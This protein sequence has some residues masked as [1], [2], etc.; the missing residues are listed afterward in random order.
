MNRAAVLVVLTSLAIVGVGAWLWFD[1][2]D[3][4]GLKFGGY[5]EAEQVQVGSRLGGRVVQVLVEEGSEVEAGQD[6]AIFETDEVEAQLREA[7]SML[8]EA[9]EK[10]NL[11]NAGTREEEVNQVK[12]QVKR[13][14]DKWSMLK[15]GPRPEETE[16]ARLLY[17]RSEKEY[18]SARQNFDR[19]VALA[20]RNAAAQETVDN[21][22]KLMETALRT[23]EADK[24][25]WELLKR[26]R[27]EEIDMAEHELEE[28]QAVL[29]M[30][31]NGPR[32]EEKRQ[33][34]AAIEAAQARIDR[35]EVLFREGTVKAPFACVVESFF[36]S[37]GLQPGDLVAPG[38]PLAT[39]VRKDQFWVRAFVP[40]TELG[41][42]RD[43]EPVAIT[44]DS[45][46]NRRFPGVVLRINRIA[47]FTPRNV[48][49]FK[50]RQDMMFPIK[51]RIDDSAGLL[52]PGM[53]ATVHVAKKG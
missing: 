43:N 45:F 38:V 36:K 22:S 26:N 29:D 27:Q 13:L 37:S 30:A 49:T 24:Q 40:E 17:E 51:V 39:L 31:I 42:I 19:V 48:Q 3:E 44:V 14:N 16:Q 46:P 47:E 4:S 28:A 6:L 53:A 18:K 11:L 10:L 9:T 7:K 41:F 52:R 1:R 21:A 2:E 8:V 23:M 32:P 50:E 33:A 15:A 12:A 20:E 35:L 5:I 34:Q 25:K